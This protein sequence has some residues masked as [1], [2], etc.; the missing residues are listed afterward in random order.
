MGPLEK[1]AMEVLARHVARLG[2]AGQGLEDV[3]KAVVTR[4]LKNAQDYSNWQFLITIEGL[5]MYQQVLDR[6]KDIYQGQA[7]ARADARVK[8]AFVSSRP[9]QQPRSA[10]PEM[11]HS[12][13][14]RQ[15]PRNRLRLLI[16]EIGFA[17]N[18]QSERF[19]GS[20]GKDLEERGVLQLAVELSAGVTKA[21][22]LPIFSVC[23]HEGVWYCRTGNRRL[24]ALRLAH[25]F[26]PERVQD[27][28]VDVTDADTVFLHGAEGRRPKLTTDRNG[29]NCRGQWLFIRE[30]GE[31]IGI[32]QPGAPEYGSDL[33]SMLDVPLRGSAVAGPEGAP[34]RVLFE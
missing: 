20:S 30:T 22:G 16:K 21:E 18:D 10:A 11:S 3:V 12:P 15:M 33:L 29:P 25:R 24:A 34:A 27:I 32:E 5:F 26:A 1:R 7:T 6:F 14:K 8:A 28:V 9:P 31:R 13:L 17:H 19:G 23:H 4:G 2:R